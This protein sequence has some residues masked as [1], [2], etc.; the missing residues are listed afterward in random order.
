MQ[1]RRRGRDFL[2][3]TLLM[4]LVLAS[5]SA[6]AAANPPEF[7]ASEPPSET[8]IATPPTQIILTFSKPTDPSMTGGYVHNVDGV[9]VSTAIAVSPDDATKVIVT[10]TPNLASGWYMVMWNTALVG[11]DNYLTGDVTFAIA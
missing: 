11:S 9:I 3:A 8:T 2:I 7:I 10:L 6:V 4:A 5:V 1:V